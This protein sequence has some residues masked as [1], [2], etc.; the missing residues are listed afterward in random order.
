MSNET[1]VFRFDLDTSALEQ[2][3]ARVQKLI[4]EIKEGRASNRDVSELETSLAKELDGLAKLGQQEKKTGEATKELLQQKEKL[5]AVMR[6]AGSQAAGLVGDLGGVLELLMAN[7]KAALGL[8]AGL[9]IFTTVT[10]VLHNAREAMRKLREEQDQLIDRA[11]VLKGE[12]RSSQEVMNDT[13]QQ[14]GALTP[15]TEAAAGMARRGIERA[16]F[17]RDTATQVAPL[18]A[19]EQLTEET[20]N[21]VAQLSVMGVS[22]EAGQANKTL[23]QLQKTQPELVAAAQR[24]IEA[25]PRTHIGAERIA[26]ASGQAQGAYAGTPEERAKG[27]LEQLKL[28]DKDIPESEYQEIVREA[29][30]LRDRI[31]RLQKAIDKVKDVP[32]ALEEV[33][34]LSGGLEGRLEDAKKKFRQ[35][36]ATILAVVEK[37]GQQ[38]PGGDAEVAQPPTV[39]NIVNNQPGTQYNAPPTTTGKLGSG[40]IGTSTFNGR[41]GK[42]HGNSVP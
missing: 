3:A 30:E 9:A 19:M 26:S 10:S 33:G 22:F 38:N 2:K 15:E 31:Q 11:A 40:H 7:S 6:V 25:I 5:G 1:E 20:R 42:L 41:T 36:P 32:P 21:L 27:Q 17:T 28:I 8:G 35:G 39:V 34:D 12:V 4:A 37:A 16:G 18:A 23:E 24:Q 13:L 14:H 29:K